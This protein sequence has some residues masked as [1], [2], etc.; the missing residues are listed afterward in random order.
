M[1]RRID[2]VRA[3]RMTLSFSWAQSV[4]ADVLGWMYTVPAGRKFVVK[5][6]KICSPAGLAESASNFCNFKVQKGTAGAVIANYSTDSA[7]PGTN[8]LAAETPTALALAAT[9]VFDA[10][11]HVYFM[12]DESGTTTIPAGR[13]TVDGYL[14]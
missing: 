12:A 3:E 10:G 8:S 14:L 7:G 6:A 4:D 2:G 11:E 9:P 5:E 1:A 13:V